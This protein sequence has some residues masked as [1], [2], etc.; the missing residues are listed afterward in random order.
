MN[1]PANEHLGKRHFD[2]L[3]TFTKGDYS[4]AARV[5]HDGLCIWHLP[6]DKKSHEEFRRSMADVLAAARNHGAAPAFRYAVVP[7]G[8]RLD[9]ETFPYGASFEDVTFEGVAVFHGARF[10]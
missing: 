4:C 7:S 3:C 1:S 6:S 5:R 9:A 2:S 10:G 8:V